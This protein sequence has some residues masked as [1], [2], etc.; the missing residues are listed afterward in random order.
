MLKQ[1]SVTIVTL[2]CCKYGV[3]QDFL[4]F[5]FF[6]FFQR[7]LLIQWS[8]MYKQFLSVCVSLL[9][10]PLFTTLIAVVG[11]SYHMVQGTCDW[12]RTMWSISDHCSKHWHEWQPLFTIAVIGHSDQYGIGPIAAGTVPQSVICCVQWTQQSQN[13]L[14]CATKSVHEHLMRKAVRYI[15][16]HQRCSCLAVYVHWLD[17]RGLKQNWSSTR[18]SE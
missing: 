14:L 7:L 13:V 16:P 6:F 2:F 12:P 4:L 9:M 10:M 11:S 3:D 15:C 17:G 8:S 1:C 5:L 18:N